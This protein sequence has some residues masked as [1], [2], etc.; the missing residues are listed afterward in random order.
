MAELIAMGGAAVAAYLSKDGVSKLLGPTAEYLGGELKDLVEKSQHNL[1]SVF[2]RAEQKCGPKLEAEGIVNPRVMKH[3]YEEAR[4]SEN[5]LLAEYFDGVLASAR[6]KDG[7][8]DRGVYY[9]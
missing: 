2:R 8:D 6:T 1:A 3:V 4:F 5:E 7:K 9:S